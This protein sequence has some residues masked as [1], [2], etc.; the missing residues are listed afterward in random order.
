MN[1]SKLLIDEIKFKREN[2]QPIKNKT[3]G[4]TFKNPEGYFAAE[5]I[6]KANCKG[7]RIG[8]AVVSLQHANFLI[9]TR[10]ATA[11]QI[12]D[13]GKLIIEKVYKKF[14]ILLEWEIKIVGETHK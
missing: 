9:N 13:L 1:N 7:L 8:D 14:Q 11:K 6:E 3:S 12:E 4:S 10:N 5:L 2:S